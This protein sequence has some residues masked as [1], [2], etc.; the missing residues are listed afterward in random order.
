MTRDEL[1]ALVAT[2]MRETLN[3]MRLGLSRECREPTVGYSQELH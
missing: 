3:L 1:A 2:H